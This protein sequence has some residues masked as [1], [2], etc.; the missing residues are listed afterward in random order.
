MRSCPVNASEAKQSS[1]D[2]EAAQDCFVAS[3]PALTR[4]PKGTVSISAWSG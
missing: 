3:L 1:S 2:S 4:Y